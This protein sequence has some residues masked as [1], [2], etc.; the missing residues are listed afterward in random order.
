MKLLVV[1]NPGIESEEVRDAILR[2]AAEGPVHVTLVAPAAVGAGP[3]A[4]PPGTTADHV[5]QAR[6]AAAVARLERA[7]AQL[8]DAGVQVEGVVGGRPDASGIPPSW[9]PAR[10]DEV[11]VSCR[12]WLSLRRAGGRWIPPD[13]DRPGGAAPQ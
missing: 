12:P 5:V 13:V 4:A 8:R 7:V 11:V 9:D 2:R 1:A 3:L 6:Y 10:F